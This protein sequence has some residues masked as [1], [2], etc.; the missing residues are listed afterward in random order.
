MTL[1]LDWEQMPSRAPKVAGV[2]QSETSTNE[3]A[4]V[5]PWWIGPA[6]QPLEWIIPQPY[7]RESRKITKKAGKGGSQVVGYDEYGDVAG[8]AGLG[9]ISRITGIESDG[10]TVW[11]GSVSRP[12]NPA[13][14]DYWYATITT[15]VGIFH[16]A[17][18]RADQP[19]DPILL[20]PLGASNPALKHPAYRRQVRVIIKRY[21]FGQSAANVP[22]TRLLLERVP[23]PEIGAFAAQNHTQG[24][25]MVAGI[26]ELMTNPLF[27]GG[28]GATYFTVAEWEALSAAVV[29]AY[30][31]HAPY[32][33]RAQPL[34]DV[35]RDL[36]RYYGGW[37]RLAGGQIKPGFF[38][39]NG[40]VA[41]GL[42]EW[43]LHDFVDRPKVDATS[44]SS[45]VNEVVVK[46]RNRA[47]LLKEDSVTEDASDNVEARQAHEPKTLDMPA[48]IDGT[49]AAK[50]AATAA[51]AGAEGE[52]QGDS[53]RVRRARS[54]WPGGA[55]L[56]AGDNVSVDLGAAETDQVARIIRRTDPWQG[57]PEFDLI[58]EPGVYPQ[59]YERPEGLRPSVFAL[60]PKPIT[61]ARILELTAALAGSPI[62]LH[63]A[64]LAKRPIS[65]DEDETIEG[66]NV[67][68]FFVH[69]SPD[70]ASYTQLGNTSGWAVRGVMR[71]AAPGTA[72]D[73]TIA[74]T[75]DADNLD[76]ARLIAQGA[77]E[78]AN[79][80]LLLVVEK[81]VMSV[82]AIALA[83]YNYDLTCKRARQ[84]T[85]AAAH[86]VGVE[87][88]LIYREELL[89]LS[90]AAWLEDTDW[91]WKLQPYTAVSEL[92]TLDLAD[93]PVILYHFRDRDAEA[94]ALLL[95]ATPAAPVIGIAYTVTAQIGDINGD[96]TR[97]AFSA[98]R[99]VA[100]NIVEWV[101]IA[102]GVASPTQ[103]AALQ[104]SAPVI[105]P[106]A[107][108]WRLIL[109]ATDAS[110]RTSEVQSAEFAVSINLTGQWGE[111]SS[112]PPAAPNA[113]TRVATGTYLAAD[114]T[115]HAYADYQVPAL[116][117]ILTYTQ[118]LLMRTD[119]TKQWTLVTELRNAAVATVRISDLVPGRSY[120]FGT[121]VF[122][123]L[124]NGSAVTSALSD[125]L[126][127]PGDTTAPAAPASINAVQG[128][129]KAVE[130]S[131]GAVAV[132]DLSE[133]HVYRN[134][135]NNSGSAAKIAEV[136]STTYV[137]ALVAI[138]TTY[139]Y[140]VRA[141]DHSE[142]VSGFSAA[143]SVTVARIPEGEV[144]NTPPNNPTAAS[145]TGGG[146]Y[147]GKDGTF[148]AFLLLNIPAMPAG[149]RWQNVL[150]R[151]SGASEW[152]V[153]AQLTNA[154]AV[155][156]RLD[157][158]ATQTSYQVATQ[159]YSFSGVA[160]A[161]VL[162]AGS[163]YATQGDGAAPAAPASLNAVQGSGKT[164]EVSWP[165]VAA[166]DL[167]EYHVYRNTVN[168][169]GSAAKI[170]EV[171][172]TTY[173]DALVSIGSTYYYWVRAVDR[174]ENVSAFSPVASAT[175]ARIP[176]GEID[177]TVPAVGTTTIV[178]SGTYLSGDGTVYSYF[179]AT[180]AGLGAGAKHQNILVRATGTSLWQVAAQLTAA[181]TV[182]ID[183]LTPG[184][185]YDF[186]VQAFS[187]AGISSAITAVAG[188]P[189][190]A[191]ADSTVPPAPTGV[192]L[193]RDGVE[194]WFVPTTRVLQ[195]GCR[196]KWDPVVVADLSHYEV[197]VTFTNAD[198]A[199]DYSW[200]SRMPGDRTTQTSLTVY[201]PTLQ[202]GYVRVRAVDHS[203]NASA[204]VYAGN[205]NVLA[206]VGT[207]TIA[208]EDKNNTS[209]SGLKIGSTT[210]ASIRQVIARYP[211]DDVLNLVSN[212]PMET[213]AVNIAGRGFTAKPDVLVGGRCVGGSGVG[214]IEITYD[215]DNPANTSS[216]AYMK[217]YTRDGSNLP[218]GLQRFNFELV[219]FA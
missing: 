144:N 206:T 146:T 212:L 140:W 192:S 17:W 88:W 47:K 63:V 53:V 23:V 165:A 114:G 219:E 181:G 21:Y 136:A 215:S 61:Q 44:P 34:R 151:I 127:A 55:R 107:G 97:Y 196:V 126:V 195:F 213:V 184:R 214:L 124:G 95:G 71:V 51:A 84:G 85:A 60:T 187:F 189:R 77:T 96:L 22:N 158:L 20:G 10:K 145:Q 117:S 16:V 62:G 191:P 166:A 176:E 24:E 5:V 9:L 7:N 202:A 174:S 207:G 130:V 6:W 153:G 28:L 200:A 177:N 12:D 38:P 122:D 125:P 78:Q 33:D 93:A 111:V 150:Y 131:W 8:I 2:D 4:R 123:L 42:T 129:G 182:R 167:G 205:A 19:E 164:V 35:V 94:P 163:P 58:A 169:A 59:P 199:V 70:G 36:M 110:D 57:P 194:P 56:Q 133:Y 29:A 139:Y 115:A 121:Q 179:D 149:A 79:D 37:A 211:C 197:K 217:V 90:H 3:E 190:T 99:V 14:P 173:V 160:S 18:G 168:D 157:D 89:A 186:A 161:V 81:E 68:G 25:S 210:A 112:T 156:L 41:G 65:T 72:V 30:G 152:Q 103:R 204:W 178:A 142:N 209:L 102:G 183:D 43:T 172:S 132:A 54:V 45:V 11:Q 128:S 49:Q 86:A 32:L 147:Q 82:G 67:V 162:A 135:I 159:A 64:V 138:G 218:V 91:R 69:H 76:L 105:F 26:F 73:A 175:V 74:V 155:T 92:G 83:G 100:G 15:D 27:G 198:A 118:A 80:T 52:W 185:Q 180:L 98:G 75:L 31:R 104:I 119:P 143:A 1:G 40:T 48:I 171:S 170:A 141:V 148:W 101:I 50:F 208:T 116:P 66:R 193:T 108:T 87:V 39:C 109:S 106:R 188:N 120:Y 154:G 46:F 201:N 137:D 216:V 134:T 113:A 13:H 203:G